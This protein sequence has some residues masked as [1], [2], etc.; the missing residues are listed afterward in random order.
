MTSVDTINQN[1][2]FV[3]LNFRSCLQEIKMLHYV[4]QHQSL[5]SRGW[6]DECLCGC[7]VAHNVSELLTR[8]EYLSE[9]VEAYQTPISQEVIYSLMVHMI[10]QQHHRAIIAGNYSDTEDIKKPVFRP[11]MYLPDGIESQDMLH[12]G[13]DMIMDT[14]AEDIYGF[15]ERDDVM[16]LDNIVDTLTDM[17][18]KEELEEQEEEDDEVFI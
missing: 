18:Q 13:E 17:V 8:V 2:T 3:N 7:A 1:Q 9:V 15:V 16:D 11:P 6:T 10:A 14:S 5:P 4:L 12:G